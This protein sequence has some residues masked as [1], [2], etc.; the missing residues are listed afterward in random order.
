MTSYTQ[1]KC[2]GPV[3]YLDNN[4]TTLM[5]GDAIKTFESWMKCYNPA[6]DSK[7][8]KGAKQMI[9]K[10][11]ANILKINGA[12][13]DTHTIIFTSGASES[14]CFILRSVATAYYYKKQIIPHIISSSIEHHSI[15]ECLRYLERMGKIEVTFVNPN[16]YG[17]I[18]PIDVIR[19]IKSN[20]A[21]ISI[22]YA[23]NETGAISNI[24]L[25]GKLAHERRIP[26][27]SDCVQIYGKYKID[28]QKSNI[29][30]I[31][32][33]CHK[34]YGPKGTGFLIIN[35]N[36]ISG[37][38]LE[39]EING[40]QQHG[41]RGGTEN[42][43][44]IAATGSALAWNFT[45]RKSKNRKQLELRNYIIS[46]LK[47]SYS[48]GDYANY[49]NRGEILN[50][51]GGRGKAGSIRDRTGTGT[52]DDPEDIDYVDDADSGSSDRGG[53]DSDDDTRESSTVG[54][55]SRILSLTVVADEELFEE[56]RKLISKPTFKPLEL[57][58]LGP[59]KNKTN[60][61]LFNT[62]LLAVAKNEG[63]AFCNVAFKHALDK[64]GVVISIASACLTEFDDSSHVM[65]AIGAPKLIKEGVIRISMS[66]YTTKEE[67]NKFLGI[68]KNT[69][70]KIV[71]DL[72]DVRPD[73][74]RVSK[75][76]RPQP[77]SDSRVPKSPT[78]S[79]KS[80]PQKTKTRSKVK[81]SK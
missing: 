62:I 33:S 51:T 15:I 4:S 32:A 7:I 70:N 74:K 45:N 40:S 26:L 68:F 16:M 43:P 75:G 80:P 23:N 42:P 71:K 2:P 57:V 6:T 79:T 49:Y 52:M 31:S 38:G 60:T 13:S 48:F 77:R 63:P 35:N 72:G 27:H 73:P 76:K 12:T 69:L 66:D 10:V 58:I 36:L 24:P 81:S 21:M 22:M 54:G 3:V 78:K 47:K 64:Q 17:Q 1:V 5:C 67:V 39:A 55:S 61:Y 9:E 14:N 53:E 65:T 50:V 44:A 46:E 29:D 8:A 59:D 20:T 25:L 56:S 30:A 18:V 34:F 11:K 41:L 19:E 37:Y 28:I